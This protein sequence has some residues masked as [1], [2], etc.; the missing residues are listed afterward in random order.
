MD[1]EWAIFSLQDYPGNLWE[2]WDELNQIYYSSHPM[3]DSR[4]VTALIQYF[5][6]ELSIMAGSREDV[7]KAFILIQHPRFGICQTFQPSQSQI[8]MAIM[9]TGDR[10]DDKKLLRC[11][12]ARVAR[13][14][15]FSVDPLYHSSLLKLNNTTIQSAA[16]NM[17]VDVEE[18]VDFEN[19]WRSRPKNLRKNISRY[20]NRLKREIGQY[21]FC[22]VS[23]TRQMK[24]AVSRYGFLE[25]RGWKGRN[26]TALHPSNQQ[27]NFYR[28]VMTSFA[29]SGEARV[30]EL[31]I[32]EK[33][34]A[35]RLCIVNESQMIILKTT[36]DEKYKKYAFGRILLHDVIKYVFDSG[37][38]KKI[39]FYTNASRDQLEW[40]TDQRRMVN[41]SIYRRPLAIFA[42]PI[43]RLKYNSPRS[44]KH[45]SERNVSH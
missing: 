42:K 18:A 45:D 9:P 3:L 26:D 6:A 2:E 29:D 27:G 5:P 44:K 33:L 34:V 43:L 15:L 25:S 19:Y 21:E 36:F 11:A 37:L 39:D 28:S 30:F 10:F 35:S 38:T 23:S 31:Y 16:I 12:P 8:V 22:V 20:T 32:E 40:A 13:L 1:L 14:D 17:I 41:S 24:Q 7:V 4:F